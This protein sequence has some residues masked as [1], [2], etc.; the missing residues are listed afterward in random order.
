MVLGNENGLLVSAVSS[1]AVVLII[2]AFSW[3][4][5]GK[6]KKMSPVDAVRSGQTGERFKKRGIMSLSKSRL[7]TTPFM[8]VNDIL[9]AK[10]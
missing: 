10:K 8:A 2:T 3:R 6:I 1:L 4:S 9:S 5:T 7:G